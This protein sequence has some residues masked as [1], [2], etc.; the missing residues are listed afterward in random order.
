M[1]ILKSIALVALVCCSQAI[2][3]VTQEDVQRLEAAAKEV[4]RLAQESLKPPLG[5][6]DKNMVTYAIQQAGIVQDEA[7]KLMNETPVTA[8]SGQFREL[9][10]LQRIYAEVRNTRMMLQGELDNWPSVVRETW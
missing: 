3:A 7:F 4:T 2:V 1:K 5:F 10:A 6:R 9:M 8:V